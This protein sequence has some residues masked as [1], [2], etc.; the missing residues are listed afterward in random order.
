MVVVVA[1]G[2]LGWLACWWGRHG[3]VDRFSASGRGRE[4]V[5]MGWLGC[6]VMWASY[7]GC[8]GMRYAGL[9]CLMLPHEL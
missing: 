5:G 2:V 7:A 8:A 1:V 4:G 9:E 6:L 3:R